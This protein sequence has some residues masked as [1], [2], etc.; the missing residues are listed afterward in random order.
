MRTGC[1]PSQNIVAEKRQALLAECEYFQVDWLTQKIRGEICVCDLRPADRLLHRDE[2]EAR[3]DPASFKLIDVFNEDMSS[4]PRDV[5]DLPLLFSDKPKP[6]LKG[7]YQDFVT[8][9]DRFS[10]GI[11]TD[12]QE[13]NIAGIVIAAGSFWGRV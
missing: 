13:V 10:G 9:L 8:R 2:E 3:S 7:T 4:L 12:L 1:R 11:V 5:L 6:E